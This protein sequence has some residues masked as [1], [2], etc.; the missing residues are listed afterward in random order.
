MAILDKDGISSKVPI[1]KSAT[2]LIIFACLI[3]QS[4]IV[5]IHLSYSRLDNVWNVYMFWKSLQI[6]EVVW[7]GYQGVNR[8][9]VQR[10]ITWPGYWPP[11]GEERS[12]DLDTD[13]SLVEST[14]S[15]ECA[16]SYFTSE[17]SI[18]MLYLEY[19]SN[20]H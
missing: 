16:E 14:E 20:Y 6:W 3:F 12:R 17:E 15:V 8:C 18:F 7:S 5:Y 10:A 4:W 2:K 19:T 9:R 1:R 13:L 11:I